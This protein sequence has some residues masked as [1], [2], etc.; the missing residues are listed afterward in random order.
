MLYAMSDMGVMLFF[1]WQGVR[2]GVGRLGDKVFGETET[3][4]CMGE[5]KRDD[6]HFNLQRSLTPQPPPASRY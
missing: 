6:P 5:I 1:A 3:S 2:E 4:L